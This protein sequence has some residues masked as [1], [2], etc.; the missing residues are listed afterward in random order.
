MGSTTVTNAGNSDL[1]SQEYQKTIVHSAANSNLIAQD[2]HDVLHISGSQGLVYDAA[3]GVLKNGRVATASSTKSDGTIYTDPTMSIRYE[4]SEFDYIITVGDSFS[5]ADN[6][7]PGLVDRNIP[8]I[9]KNYAVSGARLYI[10]GY[11][12]LSIPT[13]FSNNLSNYQFKTAIIQGG[14]GDCIYST[15]LQTMQSAIISMVSEGITAGIIHF[16]ILGVS[17]FKNATSYWSQE[18][19]EQSIAWN[20][21]L[22]N[23]CVANGYIYIDVYNLLSDPNDTQALLAAY[24]TGDGLHPN[25]TAEMELSDLI[26]NRS[27]SY[28]FTQQPSNVAILHEGESKNLIH[29]SNSFSNWTSGS[30]GGTGVLPV[31]SVSPVLSPDNI[32]Y[33]TR[34]TFDSGANTTASDKSLIAKP[35]VGANVSV[36][37]NRSIYIRGEAGSQIMS[38]KLDTVTWE[39]FTLNGQWQLWQSSASSIG[40]AFFQIGLKQGSIGTFPSPVTVDLW[41]GMVNPGNY[42]TSRIN[43]TSSEVTRDKDNLYIP[44]SANVN[45]PQTKGICF[46]KITPQFANSA[47]AKSLICTSSAATDFIHDNG[48]GE[49][50][51][52]DGTNTATT[53]G[54]GGW[55][56]GDVLL[57][58]ACWDSSLSLMSI[59]VKKNSDALVDSA[60]ATYD[61]AFPAGANFLLFNANT[62]SVLLNAVRIKSTTK[63]LADAQAWSLNAAVYEAV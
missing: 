20:S 14:V 13:I 45:F 21:W 40:H 9:I 36:P 30:I 4:N 44:L 7:W 56:V 16:I 60:N 26:L 47:T 18:A 10:P 37:H 11:P 43:T 41:E 55:A 3:G 17:P 19:Y 27:G 53:S 39:S 61:G 12:E 24:D 5:N 62:D 2:I 8:A 32:N 49:I 29:D 63:T 35:I 48:S 51:I 22:E 59:H 42:A 31:I 58:Y 52:N 28:L 46:F 23:Y 15:P 38:L 57:G 6:E 34:V 1:I 54:L 50:A 25:L 33:A